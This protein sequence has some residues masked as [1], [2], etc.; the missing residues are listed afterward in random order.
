MT[1]LERLRRDED[2]FGAAAIG[3]RRM[4]FNVGGAVALLA[5]AT[6]FIAF[7][8]LFTVPQTSHALIVRLGDASHPIISHSRS[9][10]DAGIRN[11]LARR[12]TSRAIGPQLKIVAPSSRISLPRL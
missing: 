6:I 4:K 5:L 7:F 9:G 1:A 12:P 8:S 11:C 10:A 3:R 2:K